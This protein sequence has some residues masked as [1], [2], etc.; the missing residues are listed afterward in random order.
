MRLAEHYYCNHAKHI[1]SNRRSRTSL[2]G[3]S[4]TLTIKRRDAMKIRKANIRRLIGANVILNHVLVLQD[5]EQGLVP[6]PEKASYRR[7]EKLER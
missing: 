7:A 1:I 6:G 3:F 2:L 4:Q 5:T